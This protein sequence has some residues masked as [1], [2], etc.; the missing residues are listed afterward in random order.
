M[1]RPAI[2]PSSAGRMEI[3]F[4]RHLLR[5]LS[6]QDIEQDRLLLQYVMVRRNDEMIADEE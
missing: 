6:Q 5:L 4:P 2:G 3:K 1:I